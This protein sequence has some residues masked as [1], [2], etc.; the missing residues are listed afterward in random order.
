MN[1]STSPDP[2]QAESY[3]A[4]VKPGDAIETPDGQLWV[5]EQV[6]AGELHLVSAYRDAAGRICADVYE[7]TRTVVPVEMATKVADARQVRR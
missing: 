3:A 2:G 7:A 4:L 1:D 6:L 5:V